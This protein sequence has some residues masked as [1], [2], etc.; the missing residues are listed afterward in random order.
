MSVINSF[1][2]SAFFLSRTK[3]HLSLH[4]S[5]TCCPIFILVL[6]LVLVPDLV[7]VLEHLVLDASQEPGVHL[8]LALDLSRSAV[9]KLTVGFV[10]QLAISESDNLHFCLNSNN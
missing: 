1:L 9:L 4:Y 2:V 6:I 8:A 5:L 3:I 7:L 10:L